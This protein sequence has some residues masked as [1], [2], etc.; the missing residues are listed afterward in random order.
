[1]TFARPDT[2]ALSAVSGSTFQLLSGIRQVP[3]W[4]NEQV[5]MFIDLLLAELKRESIEVTN[6]VLLRIWKYVDKGGLAL[7]G[8]G[9]L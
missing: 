3:G 6:R 7:G 9:R 8:S 5:E 2:V 4:T 1:L